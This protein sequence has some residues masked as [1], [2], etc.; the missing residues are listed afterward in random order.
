MEFLQ[1]FFMPIILAGCYVVGA[2]I[3]STEVIDSKYI[4]AMMLVL[5]GVL[6]GVLSGFTVEGI[7]SGAVS[8][9]AST[10][11]HQTVKQLKKGDEASGE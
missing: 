3:K 1:E 4:P 8:G 2:A 7:I 9:W 5:G 6:G 10:G 11:L